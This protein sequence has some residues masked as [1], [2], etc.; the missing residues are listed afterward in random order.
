M[1]HRV[2]A[3]FLGIV[4]VSAE[5]AH[6]ELISLTD[7]FI[8]GNSGSAFTMSLAGSG[9]SY[10][11]GGY[12][13]TAISPSLCAPCYAGTTVSFT[14]MIT[15]GEQFLVGGTGT[16]Q[17]NNFAIPWASAGAALQLQMSGSYAVPSL[18]PGSGSGPVGWTI[19]APFSLAGVIDPVNLDAIEVAGAGMMTLSA[20]TNGF[21]SGNGTY[22]LTTVRFDLA[23]TPM[24]EPASLGLLAVGLGALGVL[25]RRNLWGRARPSR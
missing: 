8:Q 4:L 5:L 3:L 25:R 14:Q 13:W 7:G 18:L 24:P 23:P 12:D 19:T 2:V 15:H 6:S 1:W 16:F 10:T 22:V 9:F 11:G 21:P 20:S 17:G